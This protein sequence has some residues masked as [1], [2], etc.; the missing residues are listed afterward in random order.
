MTSKTQEKV[1][2]IEEMIDT[3]FKQIQ[4]V[5]CLYL[6]CLSEAPTYF[7]LM[8]WNKASSVHTST[9]IIFLEITCHLNLKWTGY[10]HSQGFC[11]LAYILCDAISEGKLNCTHISCKNHSL[12][13]Y[14]D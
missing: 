6:I 7:V 9:Q 3:G 2:V 14:V 13:S 11:F 12:K 1:K 5:I 8:E 10:H 4:T